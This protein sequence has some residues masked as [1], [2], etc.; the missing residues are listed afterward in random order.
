MTLRGRGP[1]P[2]RTKR[3]LPGPS[4]GITLPPFQKATLSNGLPVLLVE[5]HRNP[6]VVLS[7]VLGS[8]AAMDGRGKSGTATLTAELLDAGTAGLNALEISEA[9]EFIGASISFRAGSDA[10]FGTLLTLARHL[11]TG[12][13]LFA[14][15]LV[16]PSFP[17][18]EFERIRGQ[19]LASLLQ[20]KDRAPSVA[21][22]AFMRVVYGEEHPY[23]KDPSGTE[24]S[25]QG[26]TRDDVVAF[27]RA[28]YSPANAT[29]IVVGDTTLGR[30]IP[31][32]E[33]ELGDWK[34]GPLPPP[35]PEFAYREPPARVF[36]IDRPGAPQS[37]IRIGR[38]AL[39]RNTPDYF[40]ATVMNRVLGGQFSS[41]INLN[42][43]EK[44]GFTY[45]ARSSFIFLKQPGP[46]IVSGA[47]TGAK[48]R[49]SA[50]QL[51]LEIES[52]H[53]S[54]VT[55]EELEFS[56][57][58]LTGG[59]I[60]SFETPYQVAGALQ[61]IVL[62]G[63]EEDYYGKYVGNLERVGPEDIRRVAHSVLDAAAMSVLVVADAGE[64]AKGLES[65]GRGPVV[66]LDAEGAPLAR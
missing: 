63:L 32:L 60:L 55:A 56:K 18:A 36:L 3:P 5:Q 42:L 40:S 8:G 59:F 47:F 10:T 25:V 20:A 15:I 35:R 31:L 33:R 28:H 62:Y 14:D 12:I 2:D 54:G 9:V 53:R 57:K 24:A 39:A 43:R 50:E 16:H 66:I 17:A 44:R 26:L 6:Q 1:G 41:R 49:E 51:L 61:S 45:G 48:T 58:G 34:P 37:E 38:P 30:I 65:L 64:T 52:V 29:L 13:R 22:N 21:A 27:Y 4:V 46:F 11:E 23:G 19:R 7:V